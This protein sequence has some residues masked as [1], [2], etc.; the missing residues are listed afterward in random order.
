MK[1]K[2]K[3]T[4]KIISWDYSFLI[5]LPHVWLDYHGLNKGDRVEYEILEDG[6]L[7]VKPTSK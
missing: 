6:T 7:I 2:L 1:L 5:T 4:R 3:Q